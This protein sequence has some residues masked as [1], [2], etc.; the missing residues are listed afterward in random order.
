[1]FF[2]SQVDKNIP[3]S[4]YEDIVPGNALLYATCS[5]NSLPHLVEPRV[6]CYPLT[7][8][9]HSAVIL[10]EMNNNKWHSK[11]LGKKQ[12]CIVQN[13]FKTFII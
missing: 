1:M 7:T 9:C 13:Y 6:L 5:F 3:A 11:K 8:V 12:Y 2:N 4:L 10:M